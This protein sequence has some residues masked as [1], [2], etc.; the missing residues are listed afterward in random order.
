MTFSGYT[1]V[2]VASQR[3][4]AF[5]YMFTAN[6]LVLSQMSLVW[7]V[8]AFPY[9]K[10]VSTDHTIADIKFELKKMGAVASGDFVVHLAS[11]PI[12]DAGM[13]NMVKLSRV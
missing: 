6:K 8:M 12:A 10:M 3:P 2:Q 9:L 11:M 7:G 13:T 5:V 4:K 1:A